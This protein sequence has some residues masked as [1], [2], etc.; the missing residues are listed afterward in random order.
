MTYLG[1]IVCC[2]GR[3]CVQTADSGSAMLEIFIISQEA[4][5]LD[6]LCRSRKEGMTWNSHELKDYTKDNN[7]VYMRIQIIDGV[8]FV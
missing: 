1:H 8:F 5:T 7:A 3:P 4:L 2:A 6:Q